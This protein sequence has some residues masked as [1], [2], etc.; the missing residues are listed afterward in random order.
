MT[1]Y[2][3]Q[4][5][6]RIAY[7]APVWLR[8]ARDAR[9]TAE[10]ANVS[11]GGIFVVSQRL[12]PVSTD[13]TC[14]FAIEGSRRFITGRIAWTR[15]ELPEP[16]AEPPGMGIEFCDMRDGDASFLRTCVANRLRAQHPVKVWLPGQLE[17]AIAGAVLTAHGVV[18]RAELPAFQLGSEVLLSFV[19][20]SEELVGKLQRVQV[21]VDHEHAVPTLHVEIDVQRTA[22]DL[23]EP[24]AATTSRRRQ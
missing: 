16:F 14:A 3:T 8:G 4:R 18:L 1:Q 10:I 13:V 7:R 19:G 20:N 9:V 12:L 22:A 24:V 21:M 23:P 11:E 15:P 2:W 5:L 6:P 17:P